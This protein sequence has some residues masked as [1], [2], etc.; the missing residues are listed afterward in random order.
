MIFHTALQQMLFLFSLIVVGYILSKF[1]FIPENSET[2]LSRLENFVFLPALILSTFITNF[3]LDKLERSGWLFL[4]S[5]LIEIAVMLVAVLCTKIITK[6]S[7]ERKIYLYGLCFSNFGFMGNAVVKALFPDIF[8][9]YTIFTLVLWM[10]IY[11]WGVPNLLMETQSKGKFIQ[12]LK[13]LVNPMFICMVLGIVIGVCGISLPSFAASLIDSASA[14][15]SPVAMLIT[16][17]TI[18]KINIKSVLKIK[19][20]Y[21]VSL[22]RLLVIPLLFVGI[23]VLLPIKLPQVFLICA[24][25][26]LAMPLGLNTIVIPSAYGK[27]TTIASGMALVS[28]LLSVITIPLVFMLARLQ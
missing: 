27:D 24:V 13:N 15:M 11:V 26:S 6:D 25:A 10:L 3:T 20:I 5:L 1:G 23:Y 8:M 14:C 21:I 22:L 12:R 18:S 9:E 16:G 2:V 4:F 28:H 7:Y 19:R 17:M